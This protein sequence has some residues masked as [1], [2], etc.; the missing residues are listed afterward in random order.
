[1]TSSIKKPMLL[2][3]LVL[4]ALLTV[5]TTTAAAHGGG[6]GRGGKAGAGGVSVSTLVTRAATQLNVTRANLVAA[7]RASANARVDAAVEDEELDTE[8]AAELK[9][10][11]A[12]DLRVAY[13]LSRAST[14]AS[15]LK[16]TTTA[17]N[18]GFRAARRAIITAQIDQALE[19]EDITAEEAAELKEE[20]AEAELPGYKPSSFR[21]GF[22]PGSG[23]GHRFRR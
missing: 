22:G 7:I 10:N 12:D 2:A 21:L 11:V 8:E 17:L 23:G 18:N 9:E 6:G 15:N 3:V 1:M 5:G 20:L 13:Q 14:V 4:A 16:I 19:D